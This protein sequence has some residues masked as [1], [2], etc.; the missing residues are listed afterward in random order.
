MGKPRIIVFASGKRS[1][2]GSGFENLARSKELDADIVA[3]VSNHERGGVHERAAQL[4]IPFIYFPG[5]YD[6]EH[7]Q[8]VVRKSFGAEHAPLEGEASLMGWSALSGWLRKVEGLD[9][10]KTFNIHPALLSQLDGRFAGH[11]MYG[12]HIHD[13]VKA[14]LDAGEISESG[15]SMHFVTEEMDRG[16]VFFE[17]RVPLKQGMTVEEI[18]H[19][20]NKAEHE[21]QPKITNLVVH[22][23]IR[24]DGKNPASLTVPEAFTSVPVGGKE[25]I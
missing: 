8:E 12:H 5:P 18:A 4:G 1:G 21:W 17:H 23:Q 16:P 11:G 3:V 25:S 6:V 2:G 9:P 7:Y 19:V 14:A 24:W 13:A 15:F 22:R 20:V 10:K